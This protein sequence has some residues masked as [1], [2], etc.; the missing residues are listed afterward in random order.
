MLHIDLLKWRKLAFTATLEPFLHISAIKVPSGNELQESMFFAK[1]QLLSMETITRAGTKWQDLTTASMI[2][3][4]EAASSSVTQPW[5][6][7]FLRIRSY[8]SMNWWLC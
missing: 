2:P 7:S 5:S 1:G 4:E 3:L 6:C 8:V